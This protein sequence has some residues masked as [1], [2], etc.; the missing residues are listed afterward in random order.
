MEIQELNFRKIF[1]AKQ[2]EAWD[3]LFN[4]RCKYLLYGGA[5]GGGKSYFLRWAA[6]GLSLYYAKIYN[7]KGIQIGLFSEDYPTLRDRQLIRIEKEF[8]RW[9]GEIKEYGDVGYAFKLRD[10]YGGGIILLRNLDD[11]SKY[12]STEFAAECVEEL[13]RNKGETF[14]DLRFRL[15]YPNIDDIKFVGAT[16]PGGIGHA[17][18]KKKW[19]EFDSENPDHEQDRFFFVRATVYDNKFTKEDYIEQ[20]KSLPEQK[21]K[22]WLE[23]SL[24]IFEGQVFSEWSNYTHVITPFAVPH[25]WKRYLAVDWG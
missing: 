16:N 9:I 1:Q 8:P 19:I 7:V 23:G 25:E 5:A 22:A 2:I 13:T 15:R 10:R 18:V 12:M 14:E 4:S 21:R 6:L 24:D 20:L 3:L 11:P 17:W